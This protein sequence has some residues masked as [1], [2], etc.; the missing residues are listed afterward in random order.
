MTEYV[1][2]KDTREINEVAAGSGTSMQVL[3]GP[4]EAPNFALRRFIMKPQGGMPRHTNLVEH[5]QFVLKGS[6]IIEINGEEFE[7]TEGDSVYIP[8]QVS[9]SYKAGENGLEFICVVPNKE[10]KIEIVQ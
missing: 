7:V 10:D 3:I 8:A 2:K 9:H 1:R 6:G 5:E 4:H